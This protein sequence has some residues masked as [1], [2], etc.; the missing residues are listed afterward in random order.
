[1]LC[2]SLLVVNGVQD[3][4]TSIAPTSNASPLAASASNGDDILKAA[5]VSEDLDLSDQMQSIGANAVPLASSETAPTAS[6]ATPLQSNLVPISPS[7]AVTPLKRSLSRTPPL[8][9]APLAQPIAT[10]SSATPNNNNYNA[11]ASSTASDTAAPAT[12]A[13]AERTPAT[14]ITYHAAR[15][16]FEQIEAE[17]LALPLAPAD[18]RNTNLSPLQQLRFV[19]ISPCGLSYLSFQR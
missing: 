13:Q 1:V 8:A 9:T 10:S 2:A 11:A 12:K 18:N 6:S 5:A 14:V 16:L 3:A 4:P 7:V 17:H 15:S 19:L